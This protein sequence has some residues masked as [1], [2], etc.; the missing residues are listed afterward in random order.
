[1]RVR[2][3]PRRPSRNRVAATEL[4]PS[5][6]QT[7]NRHLESGSKPPFGVRL[8]TAIWSQTR[9]R[10]LESDSNRSRINPMDAR[11][12]ST[13][14]RSVTSVRSRNDALSARHDGDLHCRA[15]ALLVRPNE[16]SGRQTSTR[17]SI[18]SRQARPR[19][20]T[21][22]S[23]APSKARRHLRGDAREGRTSSYFCDRHRFMQGTIIVT[24]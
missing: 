17:S 11:R 8:E 18:P 22:I 12:R 5:W 3:D 9:N 13:D 6:S 24:R 21:V 14:V 10:H 4:G 16:A 1:M 23:T 7:R 20:P 19:R 15:R 2:I